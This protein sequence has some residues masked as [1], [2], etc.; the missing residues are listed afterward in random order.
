MGWKVRSDDGKRCVMDI[1]SDVGDA[2]FIN[3]FV[4]PPAP[5]TPPPARCRHWRR[6]RRRS[7]KT[8]RLAWPRSRTSRGASPRGTRTRSKRRLKKRGLNPVAD[9][10]GDF[11]SFSIKDPDGFD[12]Q[13]TNGTKANRRNSAPN[14]K[15]P[16]PVPFEPDGM[17][18]AVGRPPPLVRLHRLQENVRVL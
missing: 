10:S 17:E 2:I 3:D 18:D 13:V 6:P 15:L 9:S 7:W 14:G 16:G 11:K 12:I 8:V 1:G 4:P 5:P